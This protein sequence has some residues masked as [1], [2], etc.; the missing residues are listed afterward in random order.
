M[1]TPNLNALK[2][3][4]AAARH[5]NFRLA[6]EELNVTQGAVA[7]KV[8]QLEDALGRQL[9][10]RKPRGLALTALGRRYHGPVRRAFAMIDEATAIFQP[11][12]T[13]LTLSVTPSFATKWLVPRLAAFAE[14]YPDI[15]V[16]TVASEDLANF[17]S[18]GVNLAIRQG[19]PPTGQGYQ[20][21]LLSPLDLCAI[22]SPR[23]A[24]RVKAIKHVSDF[25]ALDLIQDAHDHWTALFEA[26][27]RK[28]P[29]RMLRFNQIALAMDAAA[30]GQGIAL[31]PRLLV[32]AEVASGKLID[33]WRD[34]RQGLWGYYLI[35]PDNK[36]V[37]PSLQLL[38]D[39]ILSEV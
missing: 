31:A 37:P 18:D 14:T 9:F 23:Y 22:C 12:S 5:L 19:R 21:E 24:T 28:P 1:R 3:F 25:A 39:W 30:N 35:Y 8:R 4:D 17:Q 20:C 6:A 38:I 2:M 15:E 36:T 7:Q 34:K 13:Q 27:N 32:A 33:L 11:A 16:Q 29:R 10:N 26:A